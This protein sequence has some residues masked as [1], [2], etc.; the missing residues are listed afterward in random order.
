MYDINAVNKHSLYNLI[1]DDR[2]RI[3]LQTIDMLVKKLHLTSKDFLEN[4]S[5]LEETLTKKKSL[6]LKIK[7]ALDEMP[8]EKLNRVTVKFLAITGL[9]EHNINLLISLGIE[10]E[11]LKKITLQ[12]FLNVSPNSRP[13]TYKRVMNAYNA[14]ESIINPSHITRI[15]EKKIEPNVLIQSYIDSLEPGEFFN[16]EQLSDA[17]PDITKEIFYDFVKKSLLFSKGLWYRKKYKS[18]RDYLAY[19]NLKNRD[20]LVARII[21][22]KT[23][24]EI[25]DDLNISRQAVALR[26]KAALKIITYTEEDILYRDLFKQFNI[27][28]ELFCDLTGEPNSVYNYLTLRYKKGTKDLLENIN[29]FSFTDKQMQVILRHNNGFMN[30]KNEFTHLNKLAVFDDVLFYFGRNTTNSEVLF[31]KYNEYI[32]KHNLNIDLAE[33]LESLRGMHERS[34]Y[35]LHDRSQNFRYFDI[36]QLTEGE[37][38]RLKELVD[39]PT[40]IYSMYKIY[41][42]N[43]D[44]MR[45]I[46]IRNA[47]ELHNLYRTFIKIKNVSYNRMPEFTVGNIE[48][49]DFIIHLFHEQAPIHIDDFVDYVYN[50]YYL[51]KNSLKSFIQANLF[52]YVSEEIIQVKYEEVSEEEMAYMR[53]VLIADIYTIEEIIEQGSKKIK[54]FQDRIINNMLLNKLGYSIR[55]QYI[56]K[57]DYK[58]AERYFIDSILSK[59]YYVNERLPINHTQV[60][61]KVIYDLERSLDLLK[62]EKDMYITSGMIEKAG[63]QKS[64]I[65]DFQNQVREFAGEEQY[66]S[67][68][69]LKNKGFNHELF[70]IGFESIFY[71]RILWADSEIRTITLASGYIFKIQDDDVSLVDFLKWLIQKF[72]SIDGYDLIDY[73]IHEYSI[74]VDFQK[75]ITLLQN[76]DVYYSPDLSKFFCD[77]ESFFEEIY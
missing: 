26:E 46:D 22:N 36:D 9:S 10:Y 5:Y 29:K 48:K 56:L 28:R 4:T 58:N 63:I 25:S 71:D 31:P 30:H 16:F 41:E 33:T 57:N 75:A 68:A 53:S 3:S 7:A 18:I 67:I 47:N 40:G 37:F 32:I 1:L 17:I 50:V 65:I 6:I 60:F 51:R 14:L 20:V 2:H 66:F 64:L 70:D 73:I 69:F 45:E 77:K 34:R 44:F 43:I 61:R 13:S 8:P 62:V 27:T 39:L 11:D 74:K 52:E 76:T 42:E 55:G 24:Q 38:D 72:D 19:S 21:E 59:D 15:P 35:A 12:D 49:K 23:L 54:D